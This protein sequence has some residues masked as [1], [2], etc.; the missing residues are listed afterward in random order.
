MDERCGLTAA[1]VPI[2]VLDP[3]TMI[4]SVASDADRLMETDSIAAAEEV[5]TS[6]G[7]LP[8]TRITRTVDFARRV[9]P[10]GS[11]SGA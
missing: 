10:D 4:Q 9:A 6:C 11:D 2:W 5:Y 8:E 3:Q 1:S 7:R